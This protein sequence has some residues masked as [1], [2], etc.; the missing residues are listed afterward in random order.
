MDRTT[1]TASGAEEML[2]HVAIW[3][4]DLIIGLPTSE[5]YVIFLHITVGNE[6]PAKSP[7]KLI[8]KMD[9]IAT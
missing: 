9:L 1:R 8:M 2:L 6:T 4:A 5:I 3:S 7:L